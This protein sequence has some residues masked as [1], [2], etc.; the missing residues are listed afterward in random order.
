MSEATQ[1]AEVY[2][3]CIGGYQVCDKWLKDRKDRRLELDDN[4]TY[5]RMVTALGGTLTIQRRVD[6]LYPDVE[7]DAVSVQ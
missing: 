5:C 6:V 4:R 2:E 3:Y 1:A 7:E